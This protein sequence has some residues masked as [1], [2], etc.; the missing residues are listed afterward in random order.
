MKKGEI[1][2]AIPLLENGL[3]MCPFAKTKAYFQNSLAIARFKEKDFK[4]A[5]SSLPSNTDPITN[6]LNLHGWGEIAKN[7]KR[8]IS[9]IQ[10]AQI[11]HENLKSNCPPY[12]T[13]LVEELELRY[14]NGGQKAAR[15]DEWIFEQECNSGV[16]SLAA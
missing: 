8:E 4:G 6:I 10:I 16:L 5:I 2:E 14:F 9:K 13:P 7:E 11:A 12:L 3:Q 15:T 1:K